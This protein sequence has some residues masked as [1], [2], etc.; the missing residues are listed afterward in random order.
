MTIGGYDPIGLASDRASRAAALRE[1]LRARGMSEAAIRRAFGETYEGLPHERR[2][3]ASAAPEPPRAYPRLPTPAPGTD[4][5]LKN[6]PP[7]DAAAMPAAPPQVTLPPVLRMSR[8]NAHQNGTLPVRTRHLLLAAVC[9]HFGCTVEELRSTKKD[10]EMAASRGALIALASQAA[11]ANNCTIA[12]WLNLDPS[13]VFESL[14]RHRARLAL[15]GVGDRRDLVHANEFDR[16]H[17]DRTIAYVRTWARMLASL[18]DYGAQE[19]AEA[20]PT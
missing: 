20:D 17:A 8:A 1:A 10:Q 7:A 12:R 19:A 4:R 13:T 9:D 6:P 14:R 3:G 5:P 2:G 11:L 15:A 16:V 18:A